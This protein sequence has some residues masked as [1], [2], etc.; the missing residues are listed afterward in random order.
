[1]QN[2]EPDD[3]E[4]DGTW[5]SMVALHGRLYA[6]EPNHGELVKVDP[7]D[8][9]DVHRVV[10]VSASQGHIVPTALAYHDRFFI[11]NLGTFPIVSGSSKV[12]KLTRNGQL[13]PAV[14]RLTTV[15]A[16]PSTIAGGCTCWRTPPGKA[17]WPRPR[18]PARWCAS[19]PQA[20][21]MR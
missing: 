5:Y 21:A 12:L 20:R 8:G 14:D 2:P 17:T 6:L 4:P 7:W 3:F 15:L 9:D 18:A 13:W 10:D 11:G 16:S 19:I 1:V